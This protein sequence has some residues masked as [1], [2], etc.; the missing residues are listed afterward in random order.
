MSEQAEHSAQDGEER[1]ERKGGLF[2]KLALAGVGGVMLAQEEIT[3]FFRRPA[4]AEVDPE[5]E[6]EAPPL[7]AEPNPATAW[8]DSTI[9]GVLHT[10][11]LPSR[12][13][14]DELTREVEALRQRLSSL[15]RD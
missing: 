10:L 4:P 7:V 1:P 5:S 8:I 11:S 6:E 2:Y 15:Q 3:N 14:V 13:D 9:E 12:A